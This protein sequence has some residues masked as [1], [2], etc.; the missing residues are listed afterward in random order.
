MGEVGRSSAYSEQIHTTVYTVRA[1]AR[2]LVIAQ[3]FASLLAVAPGVAY[4]ATSGC[5]RLN[6]EFPSGIAK[7]KTAAKRFTR[8]G[9]H[10]PVVSKRLYRKY[11]VL[12]KRGLGVI[13]GIRSRTPTSDALSPSAGGADPA[14][15]GTTPTTPCKLSRR[16]DSYAF[17]FP[18]QR[19]ALRTTGDIRTAV[20]F[21]D[22][23]DAPATI[24][25]DAARQQVAEPT[26]DIYSQM[27]YGDFRMNLVADTRWLRLPSPTSA[28]TGSLDKY[29]RFNQDT[30]AAADASYDFTNTDLVMIISSTDATGAS[31]FHGP[32]SADGRELNSIVTTHTVTSTND[33][34]RIPWVAVHEEGHLL[35]LPDLYGDG[36]YADE[37]Y[38][39]KFAGNYGVMN[40]VW[41]PTAPEFFAWE[42]WQLDW[43]DDGQIVCATANTTHAELSSINHAGGAKAVVVPTSATKALVAEYRTSDGLDLPASKMG[44]LVYTVDTAPQTGQGPIQIVQRA[45]SASLSRDFADAPLTA[46]QVLTFDGITIRVDAEGAGGAEITVTR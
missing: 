23:P 22:F 18:R 37:N 36:D 10:A 34:M 11:R 45:E 40:N 39:F 35:N 33:P 7:T 31:Q 42:R 3:L 46:G 9:G 16:H 32:A 27:S 20:L 12:D 28:Y 24:S 6:R 29:I 21:V 5:G 44:V 30:I 2:I 26:R 19:Q 1:I 14:A 4:G 17:G 25:V 38:I 43:I 8:S 15:I 13:C 41:Y